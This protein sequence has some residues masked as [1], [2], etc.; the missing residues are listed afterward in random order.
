MADDEEAIR[1]RAYETWR[2]EGCPDGRAEL[3]W[4]RAV[5]EL[6]LDRADAGRGARQGQEGRAAVPGKSLGPMAELL[7]GAPVRGGQP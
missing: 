5:A 4:Q 2:R 1:R 6:G 3:H 7:P